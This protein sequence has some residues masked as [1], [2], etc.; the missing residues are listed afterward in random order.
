VLVRAHEDTVISVKGDVPPELDAES[1]VS[2][3]S[4]T[5]VIMVRRGQESGGGGWV[6]VRQRCLFV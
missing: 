2:D 1:A 6:K 5:L 3:T 4:C